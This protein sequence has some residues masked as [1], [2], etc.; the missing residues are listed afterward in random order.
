[1]QH[2]T[3]WQ[4]KPFAIQIHIINNKYLKTNIDVEIILV[5]YNLYT[6]L[7]KIPVSYEIWQNMKFLMIF[8]N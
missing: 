6:E 4:I 2:A 3:D 1:M 7:S 8:D 5:N